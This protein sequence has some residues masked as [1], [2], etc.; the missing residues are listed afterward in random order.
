MNVVLRK[1][2]TKAYAERPGNMNVVTRENV[3]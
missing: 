2:Y 1:F 3:I